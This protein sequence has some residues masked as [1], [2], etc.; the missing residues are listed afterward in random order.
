[1]S[2]RR[3]LL[4]V[5]SGLLLATLP[6]LH[7]VHWGGHPAHADHEPH[8]GGQLGMA[9]DHHVELRR[10]G[11]EVEAFV[12]D[13][14]RRPLRPRQGWLVF[15]RART[16]PLTWRGDRLVAP[17]LPAREIEAVVILD[18][19]TRLAVSFDFADAG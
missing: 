17:D 1:M 14:W 12:S 7:Y 5:A 11:D 13:A 18:D 19:G 3:T 10:S 8:H 4:A 6:F 15:D 16:A 9:G 2:A